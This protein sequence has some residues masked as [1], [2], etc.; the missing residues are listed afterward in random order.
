MKIVLF[1]ANGRVGRL[2]LE[3]LLARGHEV[4][5][6]VHGDID[7]QHPKLE[8]VTGDIY[9]INKIIEA[10]EGMDVIMSTLGSWGTKKKD[11]LSTAMAT[12]IPA[13]KANGQTR[14]ISLTGT[15]AHLPH[16]MAGPLAIFDRMLLKRIDKKIL[17]DGENHL[18]L[19]AESDLDWTVLRSPI[20]NNKGD[21]AKYKLT[22]RFTLPFATVNRKSVALA[23]VD[24]AEQNTWSQ[25]A[26]CIHRA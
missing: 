19:L 15:A 14:I 9:Q 21:A 23:M 5:A 2:V 7:T 8:I 4:R 10:I 13:M 6:F 26:P 11:I 3:E 24:I 22:K 12:I 25:K 20:M 1:G 16:E 17:A 18:K